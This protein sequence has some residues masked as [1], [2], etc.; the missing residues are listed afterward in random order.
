[1]DWVGFK[2]CKSWNEITLCKC[3][4]FAIFKVP[5]HNQKS[6]NILKMKK[7][8]L[9]MFVRITFGF[10]AEKIQ[11]IK[12]IKNFM[13]NQVL[14]YHF[15]K[16]NLLNKFLFFWHCSGFRHNSALFIKIIQIFHKLK[17]FI[18]FLA[19]FLRKMVKQNVIQQENQKLSLFVMIWKPTNIV[20]FTFVVIVWLKL[21]MWVSVATMFFFLKETCLHSILTIQS[22]FKGYPVL[23]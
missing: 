13:L 5:L 22:G 16:K 18:T 17:V 21:I 4:V 15:P 14:F 8:L 23:Y 9:P 20:I 19:S 1:M 11:K 2:T 12:I 6:L 10:L 3:S 7:K